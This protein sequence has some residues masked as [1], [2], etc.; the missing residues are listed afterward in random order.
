MRDSVPFPPFRDLLAGASEALVESVLFLQETLLHEIEDCQS[1]TETTT[2]WKILD[3][4][5]FRMAQFSNF[6]NA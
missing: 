4:P 2:V 5:T 6:M 3:S 1:D